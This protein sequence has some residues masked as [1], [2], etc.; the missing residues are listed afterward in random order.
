LEPLEHLMQFASNKDANKIFFSAMQISKRAFSKRVILRHSLTQA[1]RNAARS[2][3][4]KGEGGF[5]GMVAAATR[6]VGKN[7]ILLLH[8]GCISGA[9]GGA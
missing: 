3:W 5:A 4:V 2:I 1:A 6:S 9:F 8:F 7:C